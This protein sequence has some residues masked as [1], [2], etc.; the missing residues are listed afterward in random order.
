VTVENSLFLLSSLLRY[1]HLGQIAGF[2]SVNQKLSPGRSD[3]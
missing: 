2:E 3:T 1:L